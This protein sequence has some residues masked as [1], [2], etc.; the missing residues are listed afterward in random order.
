MRIL[1]LLPFIVLTTLSY[2]QHRCSHRHT[3]YHLPAASS[4][5]DTLDLHHIRL[6]LDMTRMDSQE[7]SGCAEITLSALMNLVDTL[8]FDLLQLTVDS[9]V[10]G[11]NLLAFQYSSPSLY[12]TPQNPL[13]IGDTLT[14]KIYYHGSPVADATWGG[15]Y[16]TSGYAYNLGVAFTDEP[17][18][19]GRCWVPCFDNFVE[20]NSWEYFVLTNENRT[21]YCNGTRMSVDTVGTDSL[22]TH[23]ILNEPIPSYL[24]CVSV[25]P[26]VHVA[27]TLQLADG[28]SIPSW[29]VAKAQDTTEMK[30]S[31]ANLQPG[32]SGF[33]QSYGMY[34]WPKVGF[35]A[36]PFNGGAMEHATAIS[37]P[38]FAID[39]TLNYETLWAHELSH[40]WWGDLVTCRTAEDMWLNEGMASYSEALFLEHLYGHDAYMNETRNNHKDVLLYAHRNDGGRYPV[41]GIPS[42]ITYGDHVYNK[43]ATVAHSLRGI[44]GDDAFFTACRD[45]MQQ[46]AYTDISSEQMRDFFQ[47]Y[48]SADLDDFF[49]RSVFEPGNH[50]FR[51][52]T[53]QDLGNGNWQI[54]IMQHAHYAPQLYQHA[55]L[56]L[57]ALDIGGNFIDQ[58]VEATDATTVVNINL[59]ADFLPQQF[60]LNPSDNLLEAV[61]RE[62]KVVTSTGANN[63]SFAELDIICNSLGN[64]DSLHVYAENHWAAADG[65]VAEDDVL[66]SPD[67][68]WRIYITGDTTH[69]LTGKIRYFGDST[70]AKYIDAFFFDALIHN[71]LPEDSIQLYY[72]RNANETWTLAPHVYHAVL[73]AT[74]W[75]GRFDIDE[76]KSGDYCWGIKRNLLSVH[77]SEAKPAAFIGYDGRLV[78]MQAPGDGTL[79]LH[80]LDGRLLFTTT[81]KWGECEWQDSS[82]QF[83]AIIKWTPADSK[84][85]AMT[86]ILTYGQ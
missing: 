35:T 1:F 50:E 77:T 25:A 37:Y 17:H 55:T 57:R 5:S 26:Y 24:A 2:S 60:T 54:E 51:I 41:S 36:V 71:G 42:H 39:G 81:T 70:D 6:T 40:H 27:D 18:N 7:I 85:K 20:R 84:A 31:F 66:L 12:I 80:T 33:E 43:G 56:T 44:M 61:L 63:L 16:F 34:R 65:M 76:L 28:S 79:T 30:L 67:R 72:R 32:F 74:N 38:L 48:T 52:G 83:P 49:A 13:S 73:G 53:T 22:L 4:R 8:H 47:G 23:W 58:P 75:T 45:F 62:D 10:S 29:L 11:E 86:Q 19:Y 3:P 59:P 9:V 68:F 15:F 69:S 78:C 21:A 14:V 64:N 82:I 46:F